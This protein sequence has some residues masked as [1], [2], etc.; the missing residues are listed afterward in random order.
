[1]TLPVCKTGLSRGSVFGFSCGRCTECCRFKKIQLNP[2][3]IARM[4]DNR[5]ISTTEFITQYTIGGTV[6]Q[7]R[8]D[9]SCI[10]LKTEGCSIHNDRPLVC[11]LYPLG[12]HVTY[13]TEETFSRFEPEPGCR[14]SVHHSGTINQYLEGQGAFDYMYAADLYL[15]LLWHLL[16]HLRE[17]GPEPSQA[18]TLLKTVHTVAEGE[19]VGNDIPWI[20]MDRAIADYCSQYGIP[21][22][23]TIEA[24]MKMHITAVRR[25]AA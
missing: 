10:F 1:M 14:G 22:P 23:L 13:P 17:H 19:T 2:Y 16:E 6:L 9:G 8:P 15:D 12:R 20:D 24:R 5:A 25:W 3:E 4:A 11:R 7:S 21:E 18:K